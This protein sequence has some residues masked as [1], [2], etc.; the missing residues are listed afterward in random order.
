M[1][2]NTL[3]TSDKSELPSSS[4]FSS[5]M[6]DSKTPISKERY[7]Y[8]WLVSESLATCFIP[9]LPCWLTPSNT[10][11]TDWP[12]HVQL[13]ALPF[14]TDSCELWLQASLNQPRANNSSPVYCFF[15]SCPQSN[16]RINTFQR[17]KTQGSKMAI[18]NWVNKSPFRLCARVGAAFFHARPRRNIRQFHFACRAKSKPP[19]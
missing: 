9:M 17:Q 13:P 15:L 3:M 12:K 19:K 11:R 5:S 1:V 7:S 4:T 16:I 14:T 2:A 18:E 6:S 8:H 10:R